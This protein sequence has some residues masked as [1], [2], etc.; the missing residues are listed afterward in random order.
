MVRVG[1]G[2]VGDVRDH[3]QFLVLDLDQ[4]DRRHRGRHGLGRDRSDLLAVEAHLV[5]RED[6]PVL[7]RV[8]VVRVEVVE[9]GAREDADDAGHALGGRGVDRGDPAVGDR[10]AQHLAVEHPRNQQVADELGFAP[11]LLARVPPRVRPADVRPG[12]GNG[13]G[14]AAASSATASRMPR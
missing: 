14:H 13:R 9:I 5:D 3:R 1:G 4:L 7:D 8:S 11:Q 12:L 2:R 10:A 6:R